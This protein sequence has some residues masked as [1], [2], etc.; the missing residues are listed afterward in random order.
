MSVER[1]YI[2]Y[3]RD[4]IIDKEML[5]YVSLETL[6]LLLKNLTQAKQLSPSVITKVES[7]PRNDFGTITLVKII[8]DI[9]IEVIDLNIE[10]ISR[11]IEHRT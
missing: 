3:G 4:K 8:L 1:F 9:E 10:T 2:K 11:E 7:N 6:S 5:S